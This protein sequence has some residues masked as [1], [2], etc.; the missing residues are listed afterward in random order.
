[1]FLQWLYKGRTW[2]LP[3]N[4]AQLRLLFFQGA[5]TLMMPGQRALR[6]RK[7]LAQ[8]EQNSHKTPLCCIKQ[9][10]HYVTCRISEVGVGRAENWFWRLPS[11]GSG[12][13]GTDFVLCSHC[14]CWPP[15]AG[16][17]SPPNGFCPA[18]AP[19]RPLLEAKSVMGC[20]IG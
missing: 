1:M 12:P 18:P 20:L 2:C 10:R 9:K 13:Q 4:N 6:L 16:N 15:G 3:S 11:L 8:E 7:M 14:W 5:G 17:P 19:S